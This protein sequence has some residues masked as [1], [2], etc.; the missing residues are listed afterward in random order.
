MARVTAWAC[1]RSGHPTPL[2]TLDRFADERELDARDRALARR[3]VGV[4]IRRRG[5]LR[6]LLARYQHR[7]SKPDLAAHLHL[8]LAQLYF[9]ERIPDHAA[10]SATMEA[11]HQ[12]LGPSKVRAA[13]GILR[14]ALREREEQSSGDPRRDL[15]GCELAVAEPVFRDPEQHPLLWVEDALSLPAPLAKRWQK[16]HGTERMHELA[17]Q[18]LVEPAVSVRAVGV[19]RSALASE[20]ESAGV[21]ASEGAHP[22]VLIVPSEATGELLQSEPFAQGRATVQGEHALRAAELVG[23]QK[24]EEVLDLCAAPGGKTAVL[25][26]SGARVVAC[27]VEPAKLERLHSTLERLGLAEKVELLQTEDG[28]D[29]DQDHLFDA[30]LVDAPCSNT[31]VLAARP[32]A[33]WRF[34]PQSLASLG[35]LQARLLAAGAARVKPGGRLVWST[36]SLEPEENEQRVRTFLTENSGWELAEEVSSLPS[37]A[38]GPVDGGYAAR[39]VRSS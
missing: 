36:C 10:L 7:K 25:A 4:E 30:V 39:L 20:L 16:R 13:N 21:L 17:R 2:S 9:F 33:R 18:A 15:V 29:L 3:L 14:N 11:V 19:E 1:L 26:R 27:D 8:G 12:T 24:G 22:D 5:N 35:E 34:G 38:P 32:S 23:A 6:A 37:A 28:R 31:G